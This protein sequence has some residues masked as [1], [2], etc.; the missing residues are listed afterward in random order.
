MPTALDQHGIRTE[1]ASALRLEWIASDDRAAL[2]E[3]DNFLLDS[4]RGHFSQLSTWLRGYEP[5]GFQMRVLVAR[6]HRA[7]V[8]GAAMLSWRRGPLRASCCT[9]GP[10]IAAD[11]EQHA[12]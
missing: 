11:F 5:Y 12:G 8:G 6:M 1:A 2:A 3:W 10:T 4:P 9:I 7:I